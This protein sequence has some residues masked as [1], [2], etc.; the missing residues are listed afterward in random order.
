MADVAGAVHVSVTVCEK[1]HAPGG[2][3]KCMQEG[4]MDGA[5]SDVEQQNIFSPFMPAKLPWTCVSDSPS[6]AT[7]HAGPR[8]P[9]ESKPPRFGWTRPQVGW[10]VTPHA[11]LTSPRLEGAAWCARVRLP[12]PRQAIPTLQLL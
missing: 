7:P 9:R 5:I 10:P 3:R 2:L 4:S 12:I 8:L 11:S 6:W 1:L